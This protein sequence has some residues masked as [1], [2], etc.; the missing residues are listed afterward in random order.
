MI[1]GVSLRKHSSCTAE[2]HTTLNA[3]KHFSLPLTGRKGTRD[4]NLAGP[5]AEM[6][7]S[8]S[9]RVPCLCWGQALAGGKA[10]LWVPI[11]HGN[12]FAKTAS[13][14]Q[15]SLRELSQFTAVFFCQSSPSHPPVLHSSLL[16][17]VFPS[18][19]LSCDHY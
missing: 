11:P 14:I 16:I 2:F 4:G 7:Y 5:L 1:W 17:P 13:T 9:P 3:V 12:S 8:L 6:G 18:P 19:L 15:A 10:E